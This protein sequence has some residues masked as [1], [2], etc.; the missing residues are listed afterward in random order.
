MVHFNIS[1]TRFVPSRDD[2][3]QRSEKI[4][5]LEPPVLEPPITPSPPDR[6]DLDLPRFPSRDHFHHY[7]SFRYNRRSN[8]SENNNDIQMTNFT[9]EINNV[10]SAMDYSTSSFNKTEPLSESFENMSNIVS[11]PDRFSTP[12][13]A[14]PA[15]SS[16]ASSTNMT[17]S[18]NEN[19]NSLN[20]SNDGS[21]G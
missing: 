13:M 5:I 1:I 2:S 11:T 21:P 17:P 3:N 8:S 19:I 7:Q 16:Y 15:A 10:A 4:E 9:R 14:K 18:E 6:P 20:N 12:C